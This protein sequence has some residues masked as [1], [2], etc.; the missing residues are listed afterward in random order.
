MKIGVG[1]SLRAPPAGGAP[2][3]RRHAAAWEQDWNAP[4]DPAG[5]FL[6]PPEPRSP[7]CSRWASPPVSPPYLAYLAT[8][9]LFR[10]EEG[11]LAVLTAFGAAERLGPKG[12]LRSYGPGL[13]RKLPWQ[14][15]HQVAL[16]EQSVDLSGEEGGRNA[17]AEDGTLLRFDSVL[18]FLPMEE[19]LDEYVF[20][21]RAPVEHI[22]GL[23]TCILRNEIAN[24]RDPSTPP[25]HPPPPPPRRAS[26]PARTGSSAA[27]AKSST[28]A[29]RPS[30]ASR[31][32]TATACG[33]T[34]ST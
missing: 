34:P 3:P 7:L 17:M 26:M 12:A 9:C 20:G 2:A 25:P 24:F 23:F 27:S 16:M 11:H 5:R 13:H 4:V 33:S 29:S 30:A 31:W 19:K 6:P 15:A 1:P 22:T 18:R 21:M 32:A 10:V 8:R 28:A 14:R